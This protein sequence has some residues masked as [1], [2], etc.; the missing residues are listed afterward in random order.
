MRLVIRLMVVFIAATLAILLLI[1]TSNWATDADGSQVTY[2]MIRNAQDENSFHN[3]H[4]APRTIYYAN[5]TI[6]PKASSVKFTPNP[7]NEKRLHIVKV[8]I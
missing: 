2:R 8:C 6:S 5:T 1:R 3:V 7:A 4:N